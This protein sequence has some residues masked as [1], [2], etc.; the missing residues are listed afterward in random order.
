MLFNQTFKNIT[1]IREVIQVLIQY[2]FEDIVSSTPLH[3]LVPANMR[4]LWS[5]QNKSVF[6]Y[7]RWE[8]VR[9]ATVELGPTFVQ[10]AQILS[11][12]PDVLPEALIVEL[13]K[14]QS[15]VRSFEFGLAKTIIERE[16]GRPLEGLFEH[17]DKVPIGSAS[18]GQVYKARLHTGEEVDPIGTLDRKSTRL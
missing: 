5:R 17:I 7:S 2:G 11:N 6:D 14:L 12:R 16:S 1:R 10:F 18:I 15:E 3:T 13:Q 4:L 8:R 9:L